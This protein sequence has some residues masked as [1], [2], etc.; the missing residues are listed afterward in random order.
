MKRYILSLFI[1]AC[2][3]GANAMTFDEILHTVASNN[4]SLAASVAQGNAE[5]IS[6]KSENNLPDPEIGFDHKWGSEGTKWGIG[7]SQSFEWPEVYS[8]RNKAI[9]S[10][11]DAMEYLNKANYLDKMVE[12]KL[13]LIDI[14]GT[15][16]QLALYKRLDAQM[17]SLEMKY[18]QGRSRGEVT[19]LDVNKIKIERIALSREI[20]SLTNQLQTLEASLQNENGGKDVSAML[21]SLDNYPDEIIRP[22]SEYV[23]QVKENDPQLTQYSFMA[24]TQEFNA[25]AIE[26]SKRPGFS[27]G[28]ILENELGTYFNGFSIGLSLPVF[29]HKHKSE[30]ITASQEALRLQSNAF[31][32]DRISKMKTQRANAVSLYQELQDY[33][34][35]LE[36]S[37]NIG[38]LKKALD[39][40]EINLITYI[41]EVNFF[42]EAQ[43]NYLDVEYRYHLAL[44]TLNRYSLLN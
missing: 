41:Q 37:D 33:R 30:A 19:R 1:V 39:G 3:L 18:A 25:K 43:K 22:E 44:A 9:S 14:I 42:L 21:A 7:I 20:K 40:G 27:V 5:I 16:K 17:D 15:R 34:P 38:L 6:L 31:E 10:A 32:I 26:M 36:N 11:T 2:C 8:T 13:L 23:Q 28:Y 29:S 24:K 12:I 35:M 4:P